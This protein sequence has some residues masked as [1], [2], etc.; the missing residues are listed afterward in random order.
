MYG[1]NQHNTA[2]LNTNAEQ[3]R[4]TILQAKLNKS[5]DKQTLSEAKKCAINHDDSNRK[6]VSHLRS[7][8]PE[9]FAFPVGETEVQRAECRF[10]SKRQRDRGSQRAQG[11]WAG[12]EAEAGLCVPNHTAEQVSTFVN[13]HYQPLPTW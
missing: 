7:H 12:S 3:Y 4:T 9:S 5:K 13:S 2:L 8:F 10:H 6:L 11:L 1:R